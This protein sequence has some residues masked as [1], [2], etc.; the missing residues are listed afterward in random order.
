MGTRD[1]SMRKVILGII[2]LL[3]STAVFAQEI[4]PGIIITKD[5]YRDF[6]PELQRMLD[7][8]NYVDIV[9]ALEKGI[10][11]IPVIQTQ[12]YPQHTLLN[13]VTKKYEGTCRIGPDNELIG[14]KAGLPFPDPKNGAELI[15]NLDRRECVAN[16]CSFW[17]NFLLSDG[18]ELERSFKWHYWNLYYTGRFIDPIPEIPGN[19]GRIRMK[20]SFVITRP[21]DVKG[22]CYVRTRYEAI[23]KWDDVLIYI[24]AIRR[25]R[26][27]TG[28]DVC[29]PLLGSDM[30]YDD[31]EFMRQ[32]VTPRMNFKMREQNMLV[33]TQLPQ[34]EKPSLKG[35]YLVQ[36]PWEIRPLYVLEVDVNDPDYLYA[37]RVMFLEKQ[38]PTGFGYYSNVYDQKGRLQRSEIYWCYYQEEPEY[39][40]SYWGISCANQFTSHHTFLDPIWTIPDRGN[41]TGIFTFK[42]LLRQIR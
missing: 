38:R 5:N 26:R 20:E 24:P 18:W 25:I 14:W 28:A 11:T 36:V 3:I 1:K 40:P 2:F 31:F 42:W 12:D 6:I 22:F 27:V 13:E 8:G 37:K 16:Q 35:L 29:D 19:N 9:A 39:F 15:W 10:I 17:S 30:I 23:D 34:K 41:K 21:F 33:P 7:P 32:K 4:K